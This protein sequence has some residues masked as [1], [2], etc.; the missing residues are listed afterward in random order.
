MY[1]RQTKADN[2]W[3]IKS[4]HNEYQ[5]FTNCFF[6]LFIFFIAFLWMSVVDMCLFVWDF[7]CT[8]C[9]NTTNILVS[10]VSSFVGSQIVV[11]FMYCLITTVMCISRSHIYPFIYWKHLRYK[12]TVYFSWPRSIDLL[13]WFFF[14]SSLRSLLSTFFPVT[15]SL[16][17]THRHI[18]SCTRV[19]FRAPCN[20]YWCKCA[21]ESIVY[22]S[23]YLECESSHFFVTKFY[24]QY[25]QKATQSKQKHICKYS[26]RICL[27]KTCSLDCLCVY[28]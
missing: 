13:Q 26:F 18:V 4:S 14:I 2:V 24:R 20:L 11:I 17:Y 6:F 1:I 10:N 16:L 9:N 7:M 15:S 28:E 3:C 5:F 23:V 22:A 19:N 25:K 8:L 21:K 12:I 27:H